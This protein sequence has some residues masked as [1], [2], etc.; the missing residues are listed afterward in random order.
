[1]DEYTYETV[2]PNRKIFYGSRSKDQYPDFTDPDPTHLPE[3]ANE[4]NFFNTP[5]SERKL[6]YK[7]INATGDQSK[8]N[9]WMQDRSGSESKWS[10]RNT[11][12]Q[13]E[14]TG[15]WYIQMWTGRYSYLRKTA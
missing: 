7:Q 15:S 14:N 8:K 12:Y 11:D 4:N 13:N 10:I 3:I 1:M 9:I 5:I 6:S 2:F